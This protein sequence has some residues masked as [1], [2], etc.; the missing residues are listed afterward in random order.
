MVSTHTKNSKLVVLPENLVE[1][2]RV[3][4]K[5]KGVSLT[6]YAAEA[7]EQVIRMEALGGEL[8]DAVDIYT[9]YNISQA[10]GTVHIPRS[11]FNTM[12]TELYKV[13]RNVLLNT[14][15]EAGRWFG[16]YIRAR[17]EE[18]ALAFFKNSLLVSWNLDEMNITR[19]GL[20]VRIEFVSFVMSLE[21]TELLSS[22]I[23]G[24]MSSLGYSFMEKDGLRGLRTLWFR[25]ET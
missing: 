8:E 9:L 22:Y 17:L 19:D 15:R 7:L 10:A 16:E 21:F 12:I 14:W 1:Q 2:L 20:L 11:N 23:M 6:N 3:I 13:D 4:T 24:A 5:R 18:K 25:Q